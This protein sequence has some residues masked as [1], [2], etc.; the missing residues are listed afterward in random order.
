MG[1][2]LGGWGGGGGTYQVLLPSTFTTSVRAAGRF[3]FSRSMTGAALSVFLPALAD[4][5]DIDSLSARSPWSSTTAA[6][7]VPTSKA[8]RMSQRRFSGNFM[9]PP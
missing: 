3:N 5:T 2:G 1:G 8:P 9:F 6:T 4:A 7:T